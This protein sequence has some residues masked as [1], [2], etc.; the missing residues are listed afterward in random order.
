MRLLFS[1]LFIFTLAACASSKNTND[2]LVQLKDQP[3]QQAIVAQ[4]LAQGE[5]DVS[6]LINLSKEYALAYDRSER[7]ADLD[8]AITTL[9]PALAQFP[10][11]KRLNLYHYRLVS[12][13]GSIGYSS[14]IAQAE[15]LYGKHPFIQKSTLAPP[16]FLQAIQDFKHYRFKD[17]KNGLLRAI[18]QNPKFARS[19]LLLGNFY[20]QN[21]QPEL[22]E[23]VYQQGLPYQDQVTALQMHRWLFSIYR[24]AFREARCEDNTSYTVSRMLPSYKAVISAEPKIGRHHAEFARMLQLVGLTEL[25][26]FQFKRA[27]Q[28]S[29][30]HFAKPSLFAE[31]L[32]LTGRFAD[33]QAVIDNAKQNQAG[34]PELNAIAF[35][36]ALA[37][38]D[39]Q[40]AQAIYQTNHEPED[41][42]IYLYLQLLTATN[43]SQHINQSDWLNSL[44]LYQQKNLSKQDLLAKAD[45]SCKLLE[46]QFLMGFEAKLNQDNRAS[47]AHFEKIRAMGLTGFYETSLVEHWMSQL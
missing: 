9:Q 29:V 38:Q 6:Y 25:S 31:H 8:A 47:Q 5:Q 10:S 44:H 36:L 12:I 22:A 40:S 20:R 14:A 39:W 16:A 15:Q 11:H 26:L 46:A 17:M 45:D 41:A 32:F 7:I 13:K 43:S 3:Q 2:K 37:N 18:E 1:L 23:Y 35:Y 33:A 34:S 4:K 21:R 24:Q 30:E 27:S 42:H 19:Y 28:L